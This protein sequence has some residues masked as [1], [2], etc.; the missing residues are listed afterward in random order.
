MSD[1]N[2]LKK[3]EKIL[4]KYTILI[5]IYSQTVSSNKSSTL[6]AHM[7]YAAIMSPPFLSM[8]LHTAFFTC[9]T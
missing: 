5:R 8:A 3:K 1:V 2:S 4:V 9:F 7:P 6:Y